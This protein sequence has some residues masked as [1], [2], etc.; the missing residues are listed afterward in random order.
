MPCC[1]THGRREQPTTQEVSG[2]YWFA[3]PLIVSTAHI[4]VL[5]TWKNSLG[6]HA[7]NQKGKNLLISSEKYLAFES[8][9]SNST[10]TN[11]IGSL[12]QKTILYR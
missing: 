12:Q 6:M 10:G 4:G 2:T 3:S 5:Y 1:N 11:E 7:P 9:T 8:N